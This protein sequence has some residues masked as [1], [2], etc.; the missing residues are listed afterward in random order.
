MDT[1]ET[2]SS[3][4]L[5]NDM[6]IENGV[7]LTVNGTYDCYANIYLKGTAHIVTSNGGTINFFNNKGIIA[8][9]YPQIL[10]TASHKLILDFGSASTGTG[11]Q[12]LQGAQFIMN[13]CILK[14]A[15]NLVSCNA[16]Q[17]QTSINYCDFQN[18]SG[19][20]IS[21]SG[22]STRVPGINYCTFTNTDYGIFAAGQSSITIYDNTFTDNK[23]AISLSQ[24]PNVQIIFNDISSDLESDPGI[25]LSSCGGNI[26]DNSISGHS[27]GISL[28][29]SSLVIGAN[30][31]MHNKRNGIFVGSGSS[32]DLRAA[33][34]GHPPNPY[35]I[36]GYNLIF[37][38]GGYCSGIC[39]VGDDGSEI[40]LNRA[41]I[42]LDNG[43]NYIADNRRVS[44]PLVTTLYLMSGSVFREPLYV[45]NNAWGDTV[46]S[47]RFGNIDVVFSPYN[48]TVCPL[49]IDGK[50]LVIEDN[51]GEVID[52][53]YSNGQINYTVSSLDL[54]YSEAAEDMINRDYSA[55]DAIFNSIISSAP[56]DTSSQAA[57]LGLYK[58]ARL[59]HSDSTRL[60]NLRDLFSTNIPAINDSVMMKIVSQLS[61]LTLVDENQYNEAMYGFSDIINQNPESDEAMFAEID[62][63]TTS[64]LANNGNDTTL[65]KSML[66]NLLVKST[67]DMQDKMNELI[68]QR[69]GVEENETAKETMP[70]EY[71]LY[72]NF[73]NPFN[74]TT[75]IMFGIPEKT[76]VELSVYNILGQRVKTLISNEVR[77]PGRYEVNFNGSSLASGVYIYRLITKNYS[78][79]KKMLLVK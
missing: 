49:P 75:T 40:Y 45:T 32:P 38:N 15:D 51:D 57:Y 54:S 3:A 34:I 63:M 18:T 9:G 1:N 6:T 13:Y 65:H 55:A 20:A 23:I 53:V 8:E 72:S 2:I 71:S 41:N 39:D 56:G 10:G 24:V 70:T 78:Q 14:N 11:I 43:C 44:P 36:S 66:K 26:R 29:N 17:F 79:A 69:F 35:P 33:L 7:T 12:I 47:G 19:Y 16:P 60:T 68:K 73:P 28:G 62:A 21:F 76:S 58:S 22:T 67:K 42:L 61:L 77:N 74:P 25:F 64:L 46:Y 31:I 5:M 59:Q 30:T 50:S 37:E 52:T 4:T 27:I 48:D